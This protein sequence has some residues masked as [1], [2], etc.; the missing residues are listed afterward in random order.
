MVR[1]CCEDYFEGDW[2]RLSILGFENRSLSS[3]FRLSG[4]TAAADLCAPG[5]DSAVYAGAEAVS[6]ASTC[7]GAADHHTGARGGAA[8]VARGGDSAATTALFVHTTLLLL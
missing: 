2:D 8:D 1:S 7:A 3:E 4:A 5:A 6:G